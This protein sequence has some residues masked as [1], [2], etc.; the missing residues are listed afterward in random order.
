VDN[1]GGT[2]TPK[3][4][5]RRFKGS[6]EAIVALEEWE[7]V[8][9]FRNARRDPVKRRG[10]SRTYPLSGILRCECGA[11]MRG[12]SIRSRDKQGRYVCSKAH[13]YGKNSVNG[14]D[15]QTTTINAGRVHEVFW[16]ALRGLL[17]GPDLVDR[18]YTVTQ[19]ILRGEKGRKVEDRD[20]A[21]QLRK[22]EAQVNT[23]YARHDETESEVAREAAW[24]RIQQLTVEKK[25]LEA[26]K[27]EKESQVQK[28][29][30]ITKAQIAKYLSSLCHLLTNYGGEDAPYH[31]MKAHEALCRDNDVAEPMKENTRGPNRCHPHVS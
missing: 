12:R 7:R 4:R 17:T 27:A 18:L 21:Q 20:L 5:Q 26:A 11:P 29:T 24:N 14:C 2:P 25:R 13:Y 28:V 15:C 31:R 10:D 22:L 23:W 30:R 8:Q 9:K 1:E 16:P 19:K 6:H 3:Q